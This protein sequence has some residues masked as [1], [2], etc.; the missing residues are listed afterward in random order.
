MEVVFLSLRV[1]GLEGLLQGELSSWDRDLLRSSQDEVQLGE[2]DLRWV[3]Q[4][5]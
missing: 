1:H 5:A 2:R 3:L 4:V